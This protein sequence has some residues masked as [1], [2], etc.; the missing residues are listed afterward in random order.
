MIL[1]PKLVS[2][3]LSKSAVANLV[4]IEFVI[5]VLQLASS[6]SS[7]ANSFTVSSVLG[8]LSTSASIFS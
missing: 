2:N 7:E 6:P 1:V 4:A 3:V 5:V 8:A